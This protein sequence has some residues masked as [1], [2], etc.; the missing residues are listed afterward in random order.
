MKYLL[1]SFLFVSAF[2]FLYGQNIPT[3]ISS[4]S[5]GIYQKNASWLPKAYV[6]NATCACLETPNEPKSN[7]IREVLQTRLSET[8]QH[9]KDIAAEKKK[10]YEAKK[11][12][13]FRYNRFVRK[14]LTPIIY[15]DHIV[16]YQMAD[17]EGDPAPYFAWKKV[18]TIPIKDCDIVWFFIRYGGGSC[19]GN[20]G[21]W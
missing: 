6:N 10:L 17:C 4:D 21:K 12:S 16:A 5:C 13:K 19:Y 20:W 8:P 11:I 7:I 1:F 14:Q 18:T 9:I 2:S 15:A 3:G